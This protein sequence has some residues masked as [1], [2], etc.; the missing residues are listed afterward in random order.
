[1]QLHMNASS[2]FTRICSPLFLDT[3]TQAT[4]ALS[5]PGDI[6]ITSRPGP[7]DKAES[8]APIHQELAERVAATAGKGEKPMAIVGDCCQVIP[9]MAGLER[10]GIRPSLIWLDSHGDF[11]TWETTP[12]GFLGGMPLAMLT[13][14]GDQRMMQAVNL[15]PIADSRVVL[16]D[17]RD[18]D[19]GE[20]ILVE[21]SAIRFLPSLDTLDASSL[22]DG[23]LYVHFDADILDATQAPAFLYPVRNGPSP[24]KMRDVLAALMKTG[25]VIAFSVCASWDVNKDIDGRTFAA[26]KTSLGSL[27]AS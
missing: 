3:A 2:A 17:G 26:V 20:R 5:Q 12:S 6:M 1:M 11:N 14:R 7:G 8:L 15:A 18:L 22:P 25:R 13:G 16:S 10:S 23:P 24:Q 19:P 27:A 9:V 4:L 21:Q